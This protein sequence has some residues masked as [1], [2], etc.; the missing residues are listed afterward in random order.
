MRK[1]SRKK[2]RNPKFFKRRRDKEGLSP[3]VTTILLVAL[4]IVITGIIFLWFRGMVQE[5][6][7]KFNPPKNIALVCDDLQSQGGWDAS[8]DSS[9]GT[10]T[11]VNNGNIPIFRVDLETDS[12]G[13]T[14]T[15]DITTF[16][17][18]NSWP[19]AGLN[20]G[21]TFSGNI[22]S[23]SSV[24]SAQHIT[25]L[26]VLIGTSSSGKKTFVCGEGYGKEVL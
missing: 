18:G 11:V 21:G 19:S 8:Y 17:G 22:G 24:A 1:K 3:V 13:N 10:L 15:K 2:N 12:G 5:G 20:Q 23:D 25:V 14:Q 6:V 16:S 26:P 4:T 9:S 7:T